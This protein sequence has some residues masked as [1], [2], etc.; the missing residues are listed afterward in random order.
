MIRKIEDKEEKAN[1]CL[2]ILEALPEWFE[3]PESRLTYAKECKELPLWADIGE[4]NDK[5][6]Y[7]KNCNGAVGNRLKL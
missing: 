7:I 3:I 2:E 6:R 4:N 1:I 5:Q